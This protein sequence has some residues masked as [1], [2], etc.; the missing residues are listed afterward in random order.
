MYERFDRIEDGTPK[1]ID[2]EMERLGI[3]LPPGYGMDGATLTSRLEDWTAKAIRALIGR[4]IELEDHV[5]AQEEEI[6]ELRR[7]L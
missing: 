5:G 6:N 2:Q 3:G 4:L 7:Q 1:R